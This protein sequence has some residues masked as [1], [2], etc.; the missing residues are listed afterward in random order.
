[1]KRRW[2]EANSW[3]VIYPVV[4]VGTKPSLVRIVEALTKSIAFRSPSLS[5]D[6][7]WLATKAH[8][9]SSR[10]PWCSHHYGASTKKGSP[11]PLHKVILPLHTKPEGRRFAN[12]PWRL[13]GASTSR[14]KLEALK[15]QYKVTTPYSHTLSRARDNLALH[16]TKLVLNLKIWSIS[17]L[18]G[19]ENFSR[20]SITSLELQRPQMIRDE[21]LYRLEIHS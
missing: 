19:L 7:P 4:S 18:V 11:H 2:E 5:L 12:K 14:Y 6:S 17:S 15:N 10:S 3:C 8:A 16:L 1:V 9:K 20:V 21:A 13:Q